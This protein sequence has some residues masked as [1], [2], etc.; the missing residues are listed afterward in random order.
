MANKNQQNTNKDRKSEAQEIF[1]Q[2][3]NAGRFAGDDNDSK[4]AR[5][6]A[7]ENIKQD[8]GSSRE[9]R[10]GDR[11]ATDAEARRDRGQSHD[12][13]GE[14]QNVNDDTGRPMEEGETG[15]ARNK[16]MEGTRQNR[17]TSDSG[18]N[19]KVTK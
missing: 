16:A 12:Y 17:D 13:K 4:T 14:A 18:T 10:S 19:D 9:E 5:A 15:H 6:A 3:D 2:A 11:D 7:E 1:D 8:T